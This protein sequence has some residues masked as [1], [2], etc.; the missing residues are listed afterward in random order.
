[1]LPWKTIIKIQ[2]SSERHVYLQLSDGVIA[3]I[4]HG[5]IKPGTKMPGTRIMAEVLQLNRQTVV[6]AYDEL[7]AQGWFELI[8]SK[9]TFVSERL[10]EV[11]P[12]RLTDEKTENVFARNTGFIFRINNIIHS[13]AKP[14]RD[15]TGFH[16]GP[17]VRLVPVE[18]LARNYKSILQRKSSLILLSYVDA[19]GKQNV[20]EALSEYLNSSRGLSTTYENFLLTRGTQ[21]ALFLLCE[22]LISKDDFVVTADIGYR[23]A[24]LNFINAGARLLRVPVDENGID[25]GEVEK[26]CQRK[27][28]RAVYVT[29]HHHYPTTV[30]LSAA[31]RMKL[32][33]LAYEYKFIIIEDDYD[34]E[35]HYES[36]PIL[37]LA[38]A[39]RNG[40]VVYIGSFSKTLAPAI[41]LGYVAAPPNLIQELAKIRQI[42]DAQGD[43]ILEQAIAEMLREGEVRRHMK[44]ALKEYHVRRDLVCGF[45]KS[46]L[47]D[48]ID[49]KIPDGGLA[50]WAE[51][52]KKIK[53][54]ELSQKLLK[55]RVILSPGLIHDAS[56][57]RKLNSTRMGF[58]WMNSDEAEQALG[59]LYKTIKT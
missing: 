6:K 5:T 17:D 4:K 3:E 20:R 48:V 51:F 35:F 40:M 8:Q 55:K 41:R 28:I 23:Y 57:G 42:V 21:M 19:E 38:S 1:M 46:K 53:V 22:V 12:K 33:H 27:K 18:Q 44:K 45:L 7:Y 47:S 58:G 16:D 26:L 30:T 49:F 14:N 11:K 9:G 31:R 37:P 10:P 54:P 34:Y 59:V 24:D 13:P 32:L 52:D 15:I 29:S 56:A 39:D 50:L 25:V 2:K 36:S 43:P